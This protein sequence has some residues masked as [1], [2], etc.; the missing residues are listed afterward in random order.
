V[1]THGQPA[2]GSFL[3]CPL[4][5]GL[6]TDPDPDPWSNQGF[7]PLCV[8]LGG[9]SFGWLVLPLP[10]PEAGTWRA[11]EL[12]DL[13]LVSFVDNDERSAA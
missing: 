11:E 12:V 13:G 3:R 4:C 6:G 5:N 8:D 7:C 1:N 9:F 10:A 2:R